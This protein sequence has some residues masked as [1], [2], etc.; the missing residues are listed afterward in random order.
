MITINTLGDA[1]LIENKV[2]FGNNMTDGKHILLKPHANADDI[3]SKMEKNSIDF[4]GEYDIDGIYIKAIMGK[5]NEMNYFIKTKSKS[6]AVIQSPKI[7]AHDELI[8]VNHWIFTNDK[9]QQKSEQ[10]EL[11]GEKINLTTLTG[12]TSE[13]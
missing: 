11:E 7:L 4:P 1:Y 12:N 10:L 5:G 3:L 13:E 6:F 8:K 9:A 2:I